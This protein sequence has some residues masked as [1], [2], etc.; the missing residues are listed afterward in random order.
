M[1][2]PPEPVEVKMIA[3]PDFLR[4]LKKIYGRKVLR[5]SGASL[6]QE[7]RDRY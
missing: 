7:E 2:Q 4:R 6:L 3:K 1:G 5:I